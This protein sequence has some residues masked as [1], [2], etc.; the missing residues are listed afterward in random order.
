[1]SD[2]TVVVGNL[3]KDPELSQDNKGTPVCHFTLASN[4]HHSTGESVTWFR[5]TAWG[6]LGELC[7]EHLRKGSQIFC[8]GRLT[9]GPTGSPTVYETSKGWRANYD[10]VVEEVQFLGRKPT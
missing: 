1:M 6:K 2:F 3:G 8:R 7:A 10:I 5:V 4:R 9:P